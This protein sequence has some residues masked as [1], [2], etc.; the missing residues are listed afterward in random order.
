MTLNEF[1][2]RN[3][4]RFVIVRVCPISYVHST[5]P[6]LFLDV[7]NGRSMIAP[8]Q[9]SGIVTVVY[10]FHFIVDQPQ[11]YVANNYDY[12]TEPM[13]VTCYNCKNQVTTRTIESTNTMCC[14]LYEFEIISE[15]IS[16]II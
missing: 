5:P 15:F 4:Y 6:S 9:M 3:T 13:N 14:L 1:M 12:G 10:N 16:D 2:I 7:V 8:T 11:T